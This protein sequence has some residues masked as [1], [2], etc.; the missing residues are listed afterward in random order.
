MN[1]KETMAQGSDLQ[2]NLDLPC[3]LIPNLCLLGGLYV[4][5]LLY[6]ILRKWRFYK[7]TKEVT[8]LERGLTS[9]TGSVILVIDFHLSNSW[10]FFSRL[11]FQDDGNKHFGAEQLFSQ[12]PSEQALKV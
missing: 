8:R 7:K 2:P 10:L 11:E 3:P 12:P 6:F 9:G 4:I 5:Y 1:E